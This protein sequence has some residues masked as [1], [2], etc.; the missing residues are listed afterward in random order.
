MLKSKGETCMVEEPP[1]IKQLSLNH[2][3][4]IGLMLYYINLT[5]SLTAIGTF[6]HTPLFFKMQNTL[7][8]LKARYC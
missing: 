3:C 7:K 6:G 5:L 2:V 4:K 1:H 8:I